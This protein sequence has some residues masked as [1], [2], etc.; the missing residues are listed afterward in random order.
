[1]SSPVGR[2][3][4]CAEVGDDKEE[5][6]GR[7]GAVTVLFAVQPERRKAKTKIKSIFFTLFVK[8][9]SINLSIISSVKDYLLTRK[10]SGAIINL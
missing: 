5:V 1:M 2:G 8:K 7:D 4:D 6:G 10:I 9:M 3:T